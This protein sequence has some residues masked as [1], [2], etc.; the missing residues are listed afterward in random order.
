MKFFKKLF[1]LIFLPVLVTAQNNNL[2]NINFIAN[3]LVKNIRSA[4]TEQI[5][6]QTNKKIYTPKEN[7]WF[8]AFE[9]DSATGRLINTSKILFADLVDEKDKVIH[10]LT[11]DI[12]TAQQDGAFLS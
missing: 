11:L 2:T 3:Q 4:S 6:L 5:I 7:I 9:I 1:F 12:A 8:K 10:H